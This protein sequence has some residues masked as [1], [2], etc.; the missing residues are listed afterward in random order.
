MAKPTNT[1]SSIPGT[2]WPGSYAL[3]EAETG[4]YLGEPTPGQ[5]HLKRDPQQAKRFTTSGE[6]L[7]Y[8]T[9]LPDEICVSLT[10]VMA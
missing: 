8:S 2:P 4:L 9:T 1:N 3:E 7:E 10:R 6:A 5:Y